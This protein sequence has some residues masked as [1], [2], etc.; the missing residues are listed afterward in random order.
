MELESRFSKDEI[1]EAVARVADEV[2][3]DYQNEV[4]LLVGILT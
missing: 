1:A 4:P 2:S 3:A